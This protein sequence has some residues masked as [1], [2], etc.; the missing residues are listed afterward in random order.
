MY[1][2]NIN[3]LVVHLIHF[4][5]T[6]ILLGTEQTQEQAELSHNLLHSGGTVYIQ[7]EMLILP[8]NLPVDFT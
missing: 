7:L 5:S 6:V 8:V 2:F 4:Y 1:L 3:L